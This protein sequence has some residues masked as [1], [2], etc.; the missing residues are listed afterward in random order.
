MRAMGK[1]LCPQLLVHL[2]RIAARMHPHLAE[3][4]H[5]ARLHEGL[6]VIG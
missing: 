2:H 6:H 5:E 3:I 4:T 1:R